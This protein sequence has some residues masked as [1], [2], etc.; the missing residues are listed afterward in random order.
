MVQEGSFVQ[1]S[2]ALQAGSFIQEI[3]AKHDTP[4]VDLCNDI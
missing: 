3:I 2:L 4:V 1:K